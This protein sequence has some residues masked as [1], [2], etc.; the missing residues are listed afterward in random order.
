[1]EQVRL[2]FKGMWDDALIGLLHVTPK[3]HLWPRVYCPTGWW[4]ASGQTCIPFQP[5][6]VAPTHFCQVSGCSLTIDIKTIVMEYMCN[7]HQ[8]PAFAYHY[9]FLF[10]ISITF[11][12]SFKVPFWNSNKINWNK[13]SPLLLNWF[14]EQSHY[15]FTYILGYNWNHNN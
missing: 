6:P 1:M 4:E 2:L 11:L 14:S 15:G 7:I 13:F 9:K 3:P 5:V 12:K 8:T 10:D